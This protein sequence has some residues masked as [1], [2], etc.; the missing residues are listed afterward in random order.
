MT[1]RWEI[2]VELLTR[3]RYGVRLMLDLALHYGE[4]PVPLKDIAQRQEI[5]EKYLW[6][7]AWSLK[8]MGLIRSTRGSYGGFALAKPPSEIDMEEIV[9]ALEGSL[10]LVEC[11]DDPSICNRVQIC[12]SRDL[13]IALSDSVAQILGAVTLEDMVESRRKKGTCIASLEVRY[14]GGESM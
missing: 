10:C 11:V 1:E 9:R 14:F 8:T 3:A 2:E 6:N 7:L 5:S 4:G 13:W 12:V